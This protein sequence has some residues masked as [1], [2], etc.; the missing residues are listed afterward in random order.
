MEKMNTTDHLHNNTSLTH[1]AAI[2][3]YFEFFL[4]DWF[5]SF[6]PT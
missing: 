6:S 3:Y 1:I 5:P 2:S 4:T